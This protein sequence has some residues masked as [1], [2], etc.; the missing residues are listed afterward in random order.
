MIEIKVLSFSG[1]YFYLKQYL[2][3]KEKD[4]SIQYKKL[5]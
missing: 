4:T 3:L 1:E 5:A 2:I